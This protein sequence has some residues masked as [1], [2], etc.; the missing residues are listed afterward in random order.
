[1][2]LR[3]QFGCMLDTQR[4]RVMQAKRYKGLYVVLQ[5]STQPDKQHYCVQ[6][7][8]NGHYF[9]SVKEMNLYIAGRWGKQYTY[10]GTPTPGECGEMQLQG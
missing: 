5:E 10:R 2:E 8:G 3:E 1:M 9:E 4:Y 7:A 6:Y